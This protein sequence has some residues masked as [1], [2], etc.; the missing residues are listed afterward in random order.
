MVELSRGGRLPVV[1]RVH[2]WGWGGL[3][4]DSAAAASLWAQ[5]GRCGV[6]GPPLTSHL[7]PRPQACLPVRG[8]SFRLKD[9]ESNPFSELSRRLL[10]CS[11]VFQ[12]SSGPLYLDS[13]LQEGFGAAGLTWG[14]LV[15]TGDLAPTGRRA[16]AWPHVLWRV[17]RVPPSPVCLG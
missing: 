1:W 9:A 2:V 8:A 12:P 3:G 15:V 13:P 14:P 16:L 7:C 6:A 11:S 17:S 5:S 10:E 4:A